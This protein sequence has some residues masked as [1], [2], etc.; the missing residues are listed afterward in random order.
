MP[1]KPTPTSGEKRKQRGR[2]RPP[3]S[4]PTVEKGELPGVEAGPKT[5]AL[6]AGLNRVTWWIFG[7]I[8]LGSVAMAVGTWW[9]IWGC[10]CGG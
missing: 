4:A 5:L 1:R 3:A 7:A 2:G 10:G 6:Y 9:Q 8:L